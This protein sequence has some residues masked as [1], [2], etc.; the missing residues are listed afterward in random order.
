MTD[1]VT[2]DPTN[3]GVEP[4]RTVDPDVFISDS[5]TDI[6]SL[7]PEEITK[8][9]YPVNIRTKS[10]DQNWNDRVN[11]SF[12]DFARARVG[13]DFREEMGRLSYSEQGGITRGLTNIGNNIAGYAAQGFGAMFG[14]DDIVD[15]LVGNGEPKAPNALYRWGEEKVKQVQSDA[16]IL[17]NDESIDL[18]FKWLSNLFTDAFGSVGMILPD[19]L[20]TVGL[21]AATAHFGGAGGLTG[22]ARTGQSLIKAANILKKTLQTSKSATQRAKALRD[23]SA[24]VNAT[25]R[26]GYKSL[27]KVQKAI[28]HTTPVLSRSNE[29]FMEAIGTYDSMYNDLRSRGYSVDEAKAFAQAGAKDTYLSQMPLAILDM[30]QVRSIT[31]ALGKK[32]YAYTSLENFVSEGAEE[33]FQSAVA[34]YATQ[35]NDP[36]TKD[37]TLGDSLSHTFTEAE[38]LHAFLAGG[39]GGAGMSTVGKYGSEKLGKINSNY[40]L[41]IYGKK[42]F[43]DFAKSTRQG[44]ILEKMGRFDGETKLINARL[45]NTQRAVNALVIDDQNKYVDKNSAFDK[46]IDSY[47]S[48][49]ELNT[50]EEIDKVL[51]DSGIED[52]NIFKENLKVLKEDALKTKEKYAE[53]KAEYEKTNPST[54][55]EDG[56]TI[57]NYDP[58]VLRDEIITGLQIDT[59]KRFAE[60]NFN[61]AQPFL[62]VE[63]EQLTDVE[64]VEDYIDLKLLEDSSPSFEDF[65]LKRKE[66]IDQVRKYI[67]GTKTV[68]D[69]QKA[70]PFA[71]LKTKL[72]VN[73]IINEQELQEIENF[74]EQPVTTGPS[75][76][77]T[78]PNAEKSEE[79]KVLE[80]P[81][82]EEPKNQQE[83][84]PTVQSSTKDNLETQQSESEPTSDEKA[85]AEFVNTGNPLFAALVVSQVNTTEEVTNEAIK[86]L[87]EGFI[88]LSAKLEALNGK[89]PSFDDLMFLYSKNLGNIKFNDKLGEMFIQAAKNIGLDV[90]NAKVSFETHFNSVEDIIARSLSRVVFNPNEQTPVEKT[91]TEE[92]VEKVENSAT[93]FVVQSTNKT[94]FRTPIYI[95]IGEE[96]L[97]LETGE[98]EIAT[99]EN[100]VKLVKPDVEQQI[101]IAYTYS[102]ISERTSTEENF[103]SESVFRE[104]ENGEIITVKVVDNPEN[105][106]IWHDIRDEEGRLLKTVYG[107]YADIMAEYYPHVKDIFD[108]SDTTVRNKIPIGY[109]VQGKNVPFA[110]VEDVTRVKKTTNDGP[111]RN[112]VLNIPLGQSLDLKVNKHKQFVLSLEDNDKTVPLKSLSD[113]V[114]LGLGLGDGKVQLPNGKVL[115]GYPQALKYGQVLVVTTD[116][117]KT[118]V[119]DTRQPNISKSVGRDLF[120]LIKLALSKNNERD[121]TLFDKTKLEGLTQTDFKNS[122]NGLLENLNINER[123]NLLWTDLESKLRTSTNEEH[124]QIILDAI[125]SLTYLGKDKNGNTIE[126]QGINRSFVHY[127]DKNGGSVVFYDHTTGRANFI[128]VDNASTKADAFESLKELLLTNS[129]QFNV[130]PDL[131]NSNQVF[132]K[133]D[134]NGNTS[135]VTYKTYV[136]DNYPV[137]VPVINNGKKTLLSPNF[138]LEVE[139]SDKKQV[140]QVN[141]SSKTEDRSVSEPVPTTTALDELFSDLETIFKGIDLTDTEVQAI[142]KGETNSEESE[143]TFVEEV[144]DTASET[145]VVTDNTD[146]RLTSSSYHGYKGFSFLDILNMKSFMRS[147]MFD[148]IDEVDVNSKLQK[149]SVF[150]QYR[151]HLLNSLNKIKDNL[152]ES[153]SVLLKIR[154]EKGLT[155]LDNKLDTLN[156]NISQLES[157]LEIFESKEGNDLIREILD[158]FYKGEFNQDLDIDDNLSVENF[159]KDETQIDITGSASFRVKLLLS[160][161]IKQVSTESG[162]I[163]TRKGVAGLPLYMSETEVLFHVRSLLER[164]GYENLLEKDFSEIFKKYNSNPIIAQIEQLYNNLSDI[165]KASFQVVFENIPKNF[166]KVSLTKIEGSEGYTTKTINETNESKTSAIISNWQSSWETSPL[167]DGNNINTNKAAELLKLLDESPNNVL[168]VLQELNIQIDPKVVSLF[169]KGFGKYESWE[170][171]LNSG[172]L[173]ALKTS[174]LKAKNGNV[175]NNIF[176]SGSFIETLAFAQSKFETSIVSKIVNDGSKPIFPFTPNYYAEF[177]ILEVKDVESLEQQNATDPFAKNSKIEGQKDSGSNFYIRA[178]KL[179]PIVAKRLELYTVQQNKLTGDFLFVDTKGRL[180]YNIKE[181]ENV[182][183]ITLDNR[184]LTS[185]DELQT[186]LFLLSS[187]FSDNNANPLPNKVGGFNLRMKPML[188]SVLSDKSK[189]LAVNVPTIELTE[190]DYKNDSISARLYSLLVETVVQ[191]E[192]LRIIEAL[193]NPSLYTNKDLSFYEFQGLNDKNFIDKI[194][195]AVKDNPENTKLHLEILRDNKDFIKDILNRSLKETLLDSELLNS[196]PAPLKEK[197]T[198]AKQIEFEVN[199][200][201]TKTFEHQNLTQDM[202]L[203]GSEQKRNKR[204]SA[205]IAPRIR[206]LW[207]KGST[208]FVTLISEDHVTALSNIQYLLKTQGETVSL[209]ELQ[210]PEKLFQ[211]R[212]ELQK[213]KAFFNVETTDASEYTTAMEHL[214]MARSQGTNM[215]KSQRDYELAK[216][217]LLSGSDIPQDLLYIFNPQKPVY[218]GSEI[219]DGRKVQVYVKSG[220]IPLL[221]Q[222][223]KGLE[224][225]KLRVKMEELSDK[226]SIQQSKSSGIQGSYVGVRATYLTANKLGVPKRVTSFWN[227]DG[228]FN[229]NSFDNDTIVKEFKEN[230]YG[231]N[232]D[233]G[234]FTANQTQS[235]L[236]QD[237]KYHGIQQLNPYKPDKFTKGSNVEVI[238]GSQLRSIMLSNGISEIEENFALLDGEK[239]NGKRLVEEEQRQLRIINEA[240]FNI[241]REK[242]GLDENMNIK[243]EYAFLQGITEL[244]KNTSYSRDLTNAEQKALQVFMDDVNK[245]KAYLSQD[246]PLMLDANRFENAIKIIIKNGFD[247]KVPGNSVFVTSSAGFSS[248]DVSQSNLIFTS[249]ESIKNGIFTG[250]QGVRKSTQK[251]MSF[252]EFLSEHHKEC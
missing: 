151:E 34:N 152:I 217:A 232:S 25:T 162:R 8:D 227:K 26:A 145:K 114:Q 236:T 113:S 135:K 111:L 210:N 43:E 69:I 88:L 17:E 41:N 54:K 76:F 150:F 149:T 171:Y 29:S 97:N 230:L 190:S 102:Q 14:S 81:I 129:I 222:F 146:Q 173:N 194:R 120:L 82:N 157:F 124:E 47:N 211:D 242:L 63:K 11:K 77:D 24:S 106:I 66:V 231:E 80:K 21:T 32:G 40:R 101:P 226:L 245:N 119:S 90:S 182:R 48:L 128:S 31:G 92:S 49:L 185:N 122:I 13:D 184:N 203:Y 133:V 10:F 12:S 220:S 20:L 60:S 109:Y 147:I 86:D 61:K 221:P 192:L 121:N 213:Y 126:K 187:Y 27:N 153:R 89:K 191:P 144:P 143:Y 115:E 16:F 205:F 42:Q 46:L 199:S 78:Q 183:K 158:Q 132:L 160:S 251:Q 193:K 103:D 131:Y 71:K 45:M 139:I 15:F 100:Q 36:L 176:T 250:P 170:K 166:L 156:K 244:I 28:L 140:S 179:N 30:M 39:I 70:T 168:R 177:R 6:K 123:Q 84:Q 108:L 7:V 240:N 58:I 216:E 117:G 163:L 165:D 23:F 219:R 204:M 5:T 189:T 228:S 33:V 154:N 159:N 95:N 56:E 175:P 107:S 252:D 142:V 237:R 178:A 9:V 55:D 98:L 200:I 2:L 172:F 248:Q 249:T 4:K 91:S 234:F 198:L 74:Y 243:S 155:I 57:S 51:P 53:L 35:K 112:K 104:F 196:L 137:P 44:E 68:S 105:A 215:I 116:S 87:T 169:Q 19:I 83:D 65:L 241:L 207:A 67:Q 197:L 195:A 247:I 72:A 59:A 225:D 148:N 164:E 206:G 118:I 174:L 85:A 75:L 229:E 167:F 93:D 235:F 38:T 141:T 212:P 201:L 94:Y 73:N 96:G 50:V 110:Y 130:K 22:L 1:E 188:I 218:T 37:K 134:I 161:V 181:G 239:V 238:L 209:E 202:A 233:L 138:N 79:N 214:E 99:E 3:N 246:L 52:I 208:K 18:S 180:F 136:Q 125:E 62:I 224:I 223:T 64:K 186:Y 127:F